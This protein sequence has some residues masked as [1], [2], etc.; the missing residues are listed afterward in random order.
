MGF[1]KKTKMVAPLFQA[2]GAVTTINSQSITVTGRNSA[3]LVTECYG[4]VTVTDGGAGYAKGCRYT[5]TDGGVATTFFINE[6]STS[7]CDFNAM[8]TSASTITGVTAGTGLTGGGTEGS[9]TVNA[10][11]GR[12]VAVRADAIDVGVDVYN[13][14]GGTLAAGTLVQLTSFT[15][16][17]G[18][19]VVKA[20]ADA[21]LRATHVVVEAINNN[22]AGVVYPVA[23]VTGLA[24]NGQTIGDKVYLDATTAGA[25][26]FSAPTGAD[27]I[28]QVVGVVKVVHASTGEI[29][30]FPGSAQIEK[31]ATS[32]LQDTAV[33]AAKL[34]SDAVT[35]AKIL[36]ANVTEPKVVGSA[37]VG[38]L[39]VKKHALV[40]YDFAVD[41]GV[42][43]AIPLTGSPTIPDNAVVHVESYEVL[44]TVATAGADAG[45]LTLGFPT[46]GDLFTAIAVSDGSNPW[47]AGVFVQGLG[48]LVVA[49]QTPKKLTGARTFILTAGGQN[50]TAGKVVFQVSYWISQ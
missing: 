6:G 27:Q 42:A 14:T 37:G 20:D 10:A 7:S 33:S 46:D 5:K 36:D 26:V 12:G 40:V 17:N 47:D 3:G 28:S 43:G 41:G 4:T 16:T 50:I 49:S 22:T 35:T 30:F 25:F 29:V 9:V 32:M 45:T 21:G 39:F 31:I 11:A 48:A 44:T 18:V 13:N 19:V 8:E 23:T 1:Q 34:A 15:T 2:I 24:T 38:G